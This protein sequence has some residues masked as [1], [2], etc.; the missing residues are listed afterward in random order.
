M[1]AWVLEDT[2][3][4]VLRDVP[5]PSPG[6][7]ELLVKIE[8]VGLCGSDIEIH[9]GRRNLEV[10]ANPAVLGHEALGVVERCGS[11][12]TAFVAGDRVVLRGVWGCCAEYVATPVLSPPN[13]RAPR[14]VQVVKIPPSLAIRGISL[15]EVLPKLI[16]A[17]DR[18]QV[19]PAADVLVL[20]QGVTGL[21]MTQLLNLKS[22]HRLVAVDLFEEKL[23]LSR[24]F[25]AT[26]T[27]CRSEEDFDKQLAEIL[28][29]GADIVFPCH[30][31]GYGVPEA[32]EMLKWR[33][34]LILWG[35]LGT[36]EMDFFSV[37]AHGADI[38]ATQMD[39]LSEDARYCK[40]AVEYVQTGL[41]QLSELTTHVLD[42][43]DMPKA[44]SLR[45]TPRGD[46]IH[47]LV[48]GNGK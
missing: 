31:D 45:E 1:K 47:V 42:F 32:I 23:A 38:L 12:V 46:V 20:G 39:N 34:R 22:P 18:A 30:L 3:K 17:V 36:T 33:G 10:P 6:P 35:C 48:Q 44:F 13:P 11:D 28:P 26:H 29:D 21:L 25:G 2:K 9:A 8:C 15:F 4:L 16:M 19:S 5:M 37:H 43:Q 7:D 40:L 27:V 24:K 14:F 41:I